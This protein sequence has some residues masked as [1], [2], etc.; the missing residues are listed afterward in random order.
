MSLPTSIYQNWRFSL[1][2]GATPQFSWAGT[3]TSVVCHVPQPEWPAWWR[4]SLNIL[5]QIQLQHAGVDDWLRLLRAVPADAFE[6]SQFDPLHA[7]L[8]CL[9]VSL[10][11]ADYP[12][13]TRHEQSGQVHM[14]NACP[15]DSVVPVAVQ[16]VAMWLQWGH[17]ALVSGNVR[18]GKRQLQV[19]VDVFAGLPAK[20]PDPEV[21]AMHHALWVR[22]I[23]C[24]W[25]GGRCTR[26]G[27]GESQQVV[28][29]GC[30]PQGIE[31]P[32]GFR[33]PIY[34]VT[35]SVGKTT[36]ARLLYQLLR[37]SGKRLVFAASDGAWVGDGRV[38]D[39]DCIGGAT[40]LQ[41]LRRNDVQ[42]AVFEQ[43][44]GGMVKQGVPYSH[45][46]VAI[47]L[48]IQA[49]HLGLQGINT[50]E[51][52]ADVKAQGLHPARLAVLNADDAQCVRLGALR[53]ADN[54]V[55]FSVSGDPETV[56]SLSLTALGVLGIARNEAGDPLALQIWQAGCCVRSLALDGVAPYHGMLGDKTLEEILAA[57]AAAWFGPIPLQEWEAGL[58]SLHLDEQN[59]LFRTSIHRRGNVVFV[60]DKAGELASLECLES[61]V[62]QIG[63]R[64]GVVRNA[65]VF[66][67]SAGEPPERHLESAAHF[68]QWVDQFICFDRP[69]TYTSSVALPVY[70]PGSIPILLATEL[71]RLNQLH[72][73]GK[74]ITV[75]DD[76]TAVE[77]LLTELVAQ[78]DRQGG[79]TLVLINQPATLVHALNARIARFVQ[80]FPANVEP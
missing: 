72:G 55:W 48:N 50:L 73:Q 13:Q 35:G 57:V 20:L 45:S 71:Q 12:A 38:M 68:Y 43:G 46:D 39:G 6:D 18:L 14:D 33:I 1:Q 42:A 56:R 41:L 69:E 79:K 25:L 63:I 2:C 65:V 16:C 67:R 61:V 32:K 19:W 34:T 15:Y 37:R 74:P 30:L 54:R 11:L 76:W 7:G 9:L 60:L 23:S 26:I 52:M 70:S 51:E 49:V 53:S 24:Q 64:E 62:K 4:V 5:A 59:H 28:N 10:G 75:A 3:H 58:R 21:M 40:A 31:D 80:E 78:F 44:R 77:H 66:C 36:T 27:S 17:S 8:Q 22:G 47:L 29:S